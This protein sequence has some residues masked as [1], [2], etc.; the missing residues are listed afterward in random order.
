[1]KLRVTKFRIAIFCAVALAYP[2]FVMTYVWSHVLSSELPGGRHGPLDAYRHTL[3]SAV[4]SYTLS[5]IAVEV[6]TAIMEREEKRSSIM[7]RHNNR[8][9]ADIGSQAHSFSDLEKLVAESVR[10]GA[11]NATNK[12]QTTWLPKENWRAGK[13]W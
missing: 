9:G 12:D 6:V 4:V 8:H 2:T 3:A 5:P 10:S 13:L 11:I 7:D 1:M